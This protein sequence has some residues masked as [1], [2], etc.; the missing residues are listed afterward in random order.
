[1]NLT[2]QA[3]ELTGF[4]KTYPIFQHPISCSA[5]HSLRP[6]ISIAFPQSIARGIRYPRSASLISQE[7]LDYLFPSSEQPNRMLPPISPPPKSAMRRL[8]KAIHG[9]SHSE[10]KSSA[11]LTTPSLVP[12]YKSVASS[13][14]NNPRF[15]VSASSA[16]SVPGL[17]KRKKRDQSCSNHDPNQKARS[18][19]RC[20]QQPESERL[21]QERLREVSQQELDIIKQ[22]YGDLSLV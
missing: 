7:I 21:F 12:D 9:L 14:P 3:Y 8:S 20:E 10:S 16:E 5:S 22:Q 13:T 1:M 6:S 19:A 18:S 2:A 11:D 17:G 15:S 4:T